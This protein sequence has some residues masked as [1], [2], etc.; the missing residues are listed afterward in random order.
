[1]S[2]NCNYIYVQGLRFDPKDVKI[3]W[4]VD[5]GSNHGLERLVNIRKNG[6]GKPVIGKDGEP[7]TVTPKWL[8][9]RLKKGETIEVVV[10]TA[11]EKVHLRLDPRKAE[12]RKGRKAFDPKS[13][14]GLSPSALR[15]LALEQLRTAPYGDKNR[16]EAVARLLWSIE[17]L[18]DE[19][20]A[21][22]LELLSPEESWG[23]SPEARKVVEDARL[24][25]KAADR[26]STPVELAAL[27]LSDERIV[28]A[29]ITG[30]KHSSLTRLGGLSTLS[31]AMLVYA[32]RPALE[33]FQKRANVLLLESGDPV[34]R[35][36][37]AR[38]VRDQGLLAEYL[39]N[40]ADPDTRV[41]LVEQLL[42]WVEPA[43]VTRYADGSAVGEL[44]EGSRARQLLRDLAVIDPDPRVRM[45]ALEFVDADEETSWRDRELRLHGAAM[46][47]AD[48]QV[49]L[50][51]LALIEDD[52]NLANVAQ[53]AAVDPGTA[54]AASDLLL[55]RL[56]AGTRTYRRRGTIPHTLRDGDGY[57]YDLDPQS[58]FKVRESE[59]QRDYGT[60]PRPTP[61]EQ[62]AMLAS[63]QVLEHMVDTLAEKYAAPRYSYLDLED[64]VEV[65]HSI[66]DNRAISDDLYEKVQKARLSLE[67]IT[68]Q[69]RK[70][71]T[72][73]YV[74]KRRSAETKQHSELYK[75]SEDTLF[76]GL[77]HLRAGQSTRAAKF[78]KQELVEAALACSTDPE[79]IRALAAFAQTLAGSFL[80]SYNQPILLDREIE[81]VTVVEEDARG[82]CALGNPATPTDVI[83]NFIATG[84]IDDKEG[85]YQL[86]MDGPDCGWYHILSVARSHRST[87]SDFENL[88]KAAQVLLSSARSVEFS[89]GGW[90]DAMQALLKNPNATPEQK[91]RA[92]ELL[93]QSGQG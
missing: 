82:R 22:M 8:Q 7:I 21:S 54:K 4:K 51:A 93:H 39:R 57:S 67:T 60:S 15:A 32:G 72:V 56:G 6:T 90:S 33:I 61:L 20:I 41:A 37:A 34:V 48:E 29:L 42:V 53:D 12:G 77:R 63:P 1:M 59:R 38:Y 52:D 16:R 3:I 68:K 62:V 49:R 9:K 47:D 30:G 2:S 26:S 55:A 40:E 58:Y 65:L 36:H 27:L 70:E 43:G 11:N 84:I 80:R 86:F 19:G 73:S 23:L 50:A 78:L 74:A 46:F 92:T 91:A 71:Y 85:A 31:T 18:D 5:G 83:E 88:L 76:T 10:S 69:K 87:V 13:L 75:K 24:A 28:S 14:A 35:R 66:G 17:Q 79:E 25:E 81:W 45:I 89:Q 44:S 64:A